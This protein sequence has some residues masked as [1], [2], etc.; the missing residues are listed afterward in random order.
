[1][2]RDGLLTT[3][4][5]QTVAAILAPHFGAPIRRFPA[6]LDWRGDGL[7]R[8]S[9]DDYRGTSVALWVWPDHSQDA[10]AAQLTN[11]GV[12]YRLVYPT[13]HNIATAMAKRRLAY[14]ST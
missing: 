2:S 14:R 13:P 4:Q 6:V 5:K 1:M 3:E 7:L 12:P 9:L 10:V 11:A 8:A